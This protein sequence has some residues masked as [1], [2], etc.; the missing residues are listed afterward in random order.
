MK[1]ITL[2]TLT[3]PVKAGIEGEIVKHVEKQNNEI[4]KAFSV[5]HSDKFKPW[6]VRCCYTVGG[7]SKGWFYKSTLSA[8]REFRNDIN[9][10]LYD[11][12]LFL[13]Q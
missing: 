7:V 2:N 13:F 9:D 1:R 6:A 8:L 11:P 10:F 3:A 5:E 12:K 4:I